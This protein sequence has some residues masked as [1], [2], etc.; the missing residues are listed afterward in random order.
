MPRE[1]NIGTRSIRAASDYK[2]LESFFK[3]SE[4]DVGTFVD[5]IKEEGGDHL[6]AGSRKIAAG[7]PDQVRAPKRFR[8]SLSGFIRIFHGWHDMDYVWHIE[9]AAIRRSWKVSTNRVIYIIAKIMH[10]SLPD[11]EAKIWPPQLNWEL[12]T[13]TFKALNLKGEW[14]FS[15]DIIEKINRDLFDTLNKVV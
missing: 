9:H 8:E 5:V 6:V 10:D 1:E 12:K 13:I 2:N 14:S 7:K 4:D 11:I 3:A 15:E